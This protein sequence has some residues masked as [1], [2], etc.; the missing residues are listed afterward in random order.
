MP[1]ISLELLK[2]KMRLLPLQQIEEVLIQM[3]NPVGSHETEATHL[4]PSKNSSTRFKELA[5]HSTS[6][7][8]S[9]FGKVLTTTRSSVESG[10]DIDWDNS[11]DPVTVLHACAPDILRLW[12]D[13]TVQE[14]LRVR[15]MR[16]ED[17]SGL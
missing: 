17:M 15:R 10:L 8:K 3:L 7:W 4:V 9:T 6:Q 14:L 1:K 13:P 11:T 12:N 16:L 5:I 2:L